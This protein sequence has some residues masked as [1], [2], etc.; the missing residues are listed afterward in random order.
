[1]STVP[2]YAFFRG[3]FALLLVSVDDQDTIEVVAQKVACYVIQRRLPAQDAAIRVQYNHRVLQPDQT[4]SQAGI[5]PMS[6]VEVFYDACERSHVGMD[7]CSYP[8]QPLG[9]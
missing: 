8:R 7:S 9:G 1:M 2:L 5:M 4:V 3:D 6:F